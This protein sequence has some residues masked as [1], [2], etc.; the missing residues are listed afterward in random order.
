MCNIIQM[1][2]INHVLLNSQIKDIETETSFN[3]S[4]VA[5]RKQYYYSYY[6]SKIIQF[7]LSFYQRKSI[8]NG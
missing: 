8:Q 3:T 2:V 6:L 5:I 4:S 7:E 1:T